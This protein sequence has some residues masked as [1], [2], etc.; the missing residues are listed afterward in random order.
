MN[1]VLET[2]LIAFYIY[3]LLS[4]IS[5]IILEN[6]NPVKR[7]L[8]VEKNI[9]YTTAIIFCPISLMALFISSVRSG[10]GFFMP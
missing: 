7:C 10:E 1:N 2:I 4:T 9:S 6:R 5:V 3:I 8:T